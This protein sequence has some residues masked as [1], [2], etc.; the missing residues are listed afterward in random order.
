MS[1]KQTTLRELVEE[2]A[3]ALDTYKHPNI[4]EAKSR[5]GELFKAAGRG[6]FEH[7]TITSIDLYG[8]TVAVAYE[9]SA[10]CCAMS[11]RDEIPASFLDEPDPIKAATLWRLN[12][13]VSKASSAVA[14]Q[15]RALERANEV[16]TE[17]QAALSA[18]EAKE[19]ATP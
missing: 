10:R 15:Q 9:W 14:G 6:S 18:Y 7:V 12:C 3:Q 17:A 13:A 1:E 4:D 11:D 2:A 8:G 19:G 5:L 16:L